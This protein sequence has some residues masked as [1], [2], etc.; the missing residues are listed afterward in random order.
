MKPLAY[1][2]AGRLALAGEARAEEPKCIENLT[3]SVEI[4]PSI[5]KF[6]DS[7][8]MDKVLTGV[9]DIYEREG[10]LNVFWD[11]SSNRTPGDI[12][13]SFG[14]RDDCLKEWFPDAEALLNYGIRNSPD[15]VVRQKHKWALEE[16]KR[17]P[18]YEKLIANQEAE[19]LA[20]TGIL[21][22]SGIADL[23]LRQVYIFP[24]QF[25]LDF[26]IQ[27]K[28]PINPMVTLWALTTAHELGHILG[29]ENEMRYENH[30]MS[31]RSDGP[32]Y[33]KSFSEAD[34]A[35]IRSQVCK[36]KEQQ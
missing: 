26:N 15:E 13:V 23:P 5:V 12:H 32:I 19:E 31:G 18:P 6:A 9:R 34:K 36:P 21:K 14:T 7:K 2:I 1:L 10:G 24:E 20:R 35:R 27:W 4:K 3:L 25:H 17:F 11:Y 28:H 30:I 22:I 29:L 8:T 16:I 33:Q